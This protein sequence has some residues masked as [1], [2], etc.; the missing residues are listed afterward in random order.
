MSNLQAA[1]ECLDQE[2]EAENLKF[3]TE[4]VTMYQQDPEAAKN[5]YYR[6]KVQIEC[7]TD[8]GKVQKNRMLKKYLEGL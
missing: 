3:M 4:F 6:S 5:H 2:I 8:G 1:Q 7:T